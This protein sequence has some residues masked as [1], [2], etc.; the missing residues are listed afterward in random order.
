MKNQLG[1]IDDF[2]KYRLRDRIINYR[3]A[4]FGDVYVF[5]NEMYCT[6]HTI[7]FVEPMRF[8]VIEPYDVIIDKNYILEYVRCN[9]FGGN[10]IH[11]VSIGDV[12]LN[13]RSLMNPIALDKF[14]RV[15][16]TFLSLQE[17]YEE[18]VEYV[19]NHL[20]KIILTGGITNEEIKEMGKR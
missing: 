15:R 13:G 16:D 1:V 6:I 9:F 17:E 2:K 20:D 8:M 12:F 14:N 3:V 5:L 18:F 11:F 19:D 10:N 7:D 4:Y